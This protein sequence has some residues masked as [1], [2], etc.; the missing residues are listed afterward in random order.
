MGK[1]W[2]VSCSLS[3]VVTSSHPWQLT[4]CS[5]T[6]LRTENW[7]R[8]G[9][10]T[11]LTPSFIREVVVFLGTENSADRE[12]K[13]ACEDP[14]S[15]F[16]FTWWVKRKLLKRSLFLARRYSQL[17]LDNVQLFCELLLKREETNFCCNCIICLHG[18]LRPLLTIWRRR[19]QMELVSSGL[20]HHVKCPGQQTSKTLIGHIEE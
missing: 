13:E 18:F 7:L 9:T 2:P 1:C 8:G 5:W 20:E 14:I 15:S 10:L 3:P 4:L 12:M 16:L 17:C 19:H 11:L 6:K